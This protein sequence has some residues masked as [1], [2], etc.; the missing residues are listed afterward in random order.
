[1]QIFHYHFGQF[2]FVAF[3]YS[4]NNHYNAYYCCKTHTALACLAGYLEH[5]QEYE[6]SL[7]EYN[8][9]TAQLKVATLVYI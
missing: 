1:M 6:L 3:Q 5:L 7:N 8:F 2:I 4:P 9:F